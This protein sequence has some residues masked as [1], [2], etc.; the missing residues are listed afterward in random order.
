LRYHASRNFALYDADSLVVLT[1]YRKGAEAV[2]DR[3]EADA[4][5]IADLQCQ[6]ADLTQR[7][8][9]QATPSPQTS[10]TER[11]NARTWRPPKQLPLLA[12]EAMATYRIASPRWLSPRREVS[13]TFIGLSAPP[14]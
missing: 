8:R 1:V 4:R 3:L 11:C 2:R 6:L 13:Q 5:T 14:F 12:A 10:L 9:E 7:F